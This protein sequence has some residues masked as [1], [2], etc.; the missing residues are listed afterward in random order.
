MSPALSSLIALQRLDTAAEAARKRLADLPT[1][2]RQIAGRLA[3]ATAEAEAAR[4]RLAA[5]HT[6]RRELEKQVAAVD[7]RLSRFDDHRAAI[8]T[9][10]EYTALLHE[11][12]T[13]KT[14]KDSLEEQILN[15]METADLLTGEITAAG[16][17]LAGVAAESADRQRALGEERQALEAELADLTAQ[18]AVASAGIDHPVLARYDQLLK[19]RKMVAVAEMIDERCTACHVRLRPAVAQAVRRG[20]ELVHCD[21]CQRILFAKPSNPGPEAAQPSL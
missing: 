16:T 1:L 15:V 7:S 14:E 2:E 6:S 12:A 5:N 13:A 10:Q 9:N 21:S 19:Q 17:A 20:S 11:I 18:R 4:A 8:K 3:A